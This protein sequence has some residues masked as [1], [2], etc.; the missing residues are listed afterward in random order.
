MHP[1][2]DT[3]RRFGLVCNT[4][5]VRKNA[6]VKIHVSFPPVN[7]TTAYRSSPPIKYYIV[8]HSS[9]IKLTVGRKN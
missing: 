2:L 1:G 8:E 4:R 9:Y 3:D 5:R 7:N 6:N